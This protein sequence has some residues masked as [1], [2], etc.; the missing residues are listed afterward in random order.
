MT[1]DELKKADAKAK[2]DNLGATMLQHLRARGLLEGLVQEFAFAKCI[3]RKWRFDFA[4]PVQK[5]A[6]EV[7]GGTW[8]GGRHSRGAGLAADAEKYAIA[9]IMGYR[10]IRVTTDQVRSGVAGA[11]MQRILADKDGA[12]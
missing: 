10:L 1:P 7:E 2:R 6:L 11:W 5:I 12:T 9:A 8:I 4:Y 3:G